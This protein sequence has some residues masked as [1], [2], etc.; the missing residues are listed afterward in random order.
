MRWG[1][2]LGLISMDIKTSAQSCF[3]LLYMML[4]VETKKADGLEVTARR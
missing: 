4:K 2:S 3:L 1:G